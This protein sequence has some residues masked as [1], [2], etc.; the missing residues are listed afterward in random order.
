MWGFRG[1]S[2]WI[3]RWESTFGCG[4]GVWEF[5]SSLRKER[6][7]ER[8][9]GCWVREREMRVDWR[10]RARRRRSLRSI[11]SSIQGNWVVYGEIGMVRMVMMVM[12][13]F[14]II[15]SLPFLRG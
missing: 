2:V 10:E 8:N 7:N 3:L 4:W 6:V 14:Y 9:R 11:L 1:F 13:V 5:V 15:S 12:L